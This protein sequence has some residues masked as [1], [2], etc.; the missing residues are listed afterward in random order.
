MQSSA[1]QR[2]N[3]NCRCAQ[4]LSINLSYIGVRTTLVYA[5]RSSTY[6]RNRQVSLRG[7]RV[8][9]GQRS[10]SA[11]RVSLFFCGSDGQVSRAR[12]RCSAPLEA[13]G[14]KYI[15]S[16][17]G[18]PTWPRASS[19]SAKSTG[20]S[21]EKFIVAPHFRLH[22]WV[23]EEKGYF[24]DEGLDYEFRETMDSSD[25]KHHHIGNKVGAY[26]TFEQ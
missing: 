19:L 5:V 26:Q 3:C 16:R 12:Y 4:A 10:G 1:H 21:M 14:R 2:R 17:D 20:V 13:A 7:S 18:L 11:D 8:P 15:P 22:E 24:G 25:A 23:A 9:F 6:W